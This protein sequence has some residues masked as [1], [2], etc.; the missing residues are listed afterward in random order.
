MDIE[1]LDRFSF[2]NMFILMRHGN[3]KDNPEKSTTFLT[4]AINIEI[5]GIK[6]AY[7]ISFRPYYVPGYTYTPPITS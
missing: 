7:K 5:Y 1:G 3:W 6:N 2:K 4:R